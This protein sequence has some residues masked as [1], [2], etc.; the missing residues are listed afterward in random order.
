MLSEGNKLIFD[1]AIL[2][3]TRMALTMIV[4][5][6]TTR[7]VLDELGATD[8]GTYF[9]VGGIVAIFSLLNGSMSGAT[10]R[11]ITIGLGEGNQERL[12]KIFA[13]GMTAQLVII[14]IAVLL[15]ESLG[16]LYL[17]DYAVFPEERKQAIFWVFQF[18][19]ITA[20]IQLLSVPFMGAIT[21][22]EKMSALIYV[23]F[24]D[25]GIKISICILL[26]FI[27]LD[28][29]VFYAA[30]I[31]LAEIL[32]M[33][34]YIYYCKRFEESKFK[35]A[36]D[37]TIFKDMW[38]IAF[39][40]FSGSWA[41][42]SY[43][44]GITLLI[45]SF[46][47]PAANAAAGIASQAVNIVNQ[48]RANFQQAMNP[49]ITKNFAQKKL[50]EMEKLVIRSS[51]FSQYLVV[52]FGIPL[53]LEAPFLLELW[54]K[55]VPEYT[56]AFLQVGLFVTMA[57]TIREPLVTSAMASGNLKRYSLVVISILMLILPMAYVAY[58][59]GAPITTGPW[60][61]FVIMCIAIL[62]SAYMLKN[63]TGLRLKYFLKGAILPAL[64]VTI[65]SFIPPY[66][67]QML[68]D[69][70][71]IRLMIVSFIS[72]LTTILIVY[73]FGLE[74]GEKSFFK[75]KIIIIFS[76]LSFRI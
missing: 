71:W 62:A 39:W 50:P 9:V 11:W 21:A 43:T 38:R 1:N 46:F 3:Y 60:I 13:V 14:F 37:K 24:I 7:I 73:I 36:W 49:Q 30:L 68:F 4:G 56:V 32:K 8:Y 16:L 41:Y 51:K 72:L 55:E 19:V 61:S 44:V 65:F 31:L 53:L 33:F 54:L 23:A 74:K 66:L 35:F 29:L 64:I 34:F 17:N 57:M 76:K 20:I 75:N 26:P 69:Q 12:N 28:K 59:L 25:V 18:S 22:H 63:M 70:G 47:G 67:T 5:F 45:N 6:L 27:S 2:L 48:F 40:S 15:Y 58:E 42:M 10:Q 52:I